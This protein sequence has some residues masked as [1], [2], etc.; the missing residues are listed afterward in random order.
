MERNNKLSVSDADIRIGIGFA[1]ALLLVHFVP[2]VQALSAGTAI[3]MCTQDTGK[4]TWKSGL[5]RVEGVLIGGVIAL[6]VVLIDNMVGNPY[7]F[8]LL[9]GVG[10]VLNLL[11]CRLANMPAV[12]AKVSCI[13]F[14]LVTLATQGE[15]RIRY[16]LF[17]VLGTVVG[18]LIALVISWTYD[19]LKHGNK[20]PLS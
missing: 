8:T 12:A 19:R 3:I 6:L 11:G 20:Q 15:M 16:A 5:T 14:A 18:A 10:V 9:C 17:R 4:F 7:L 13:T 2:A 1:L